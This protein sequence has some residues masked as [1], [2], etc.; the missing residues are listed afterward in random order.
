VNL[1]WGWDLVPLGSRLVPGH[2]YTDARQRWQ[3]SMMLDRDV[4]LH[5]PT[6]EQGCETARTMQVLLARERKATRRT[7]GLHAAKLA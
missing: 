7:A 2:G 6:V 3:S 1:K 5:Y 4:R